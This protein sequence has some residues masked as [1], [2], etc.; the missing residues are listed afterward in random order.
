MFEHAEDISLGLV[1]QE[2]PKGC[3]AVGHDPIVITIHNN[4]R[5]GIQSLYEKEAALRINCV[6]IPPKISLQ[7]DSEAEDAERST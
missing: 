4:R 3:I 6:I 5:G 7:Y 1:G 2:G